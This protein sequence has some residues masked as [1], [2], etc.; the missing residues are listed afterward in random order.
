MIIGSW[1]TSLVFSTSDEKILTFNRFS[2]AVSSVWTGHSRVGKKDRSEFIRPGLQTVSFQMVLNA[3]LGVRPRTML[4]ILN[5]AV[6]Q[7]EVN[8]LVIGGKRVGV[9][10]WKIKNISEA[11]DVVLQQGEL[12]KAT[13]QVSMEEYL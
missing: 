11:W 8:I 9:N 7:G 6:E 12:V 13:V 5:K 1:G 10:L 2:H 3:N 4:D